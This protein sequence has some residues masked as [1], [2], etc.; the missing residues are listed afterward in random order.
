MA[1]P[2]KQDAQIESLQRLNVS[3]SNP[4][5][6]LWRGKA[7]AVS[8]ENLQGAFDVLPQHSNFMTI[9][10]GKEV[11]VHTDGG[12]ERFSFESAVIYHTDNQV[13]VYADLG[14][15]TTASGSRKQTS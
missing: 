7:W 3:V 9:V 1:K 5:A 4:N 12:E 13:S 8:S 15:P 10:E 11:V 6:V 2:E 14:V